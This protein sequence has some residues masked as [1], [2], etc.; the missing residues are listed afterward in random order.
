MGCMEHV[1][2]LF[3]GFP[4]I[5]KLFVVGWG[6]NVHRD[7]GGIEKQIPFVLWLLRASVF[8]TLGGSRPRSV[9]VTL[10]FLFFFQK[11]QLI[12]LVNVIFAE[13]F[14]KMN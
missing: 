3:Q 12:E 9:I 2:D 11:Q 1:N 7:A 8:S 10:G 5:F 4:G 13:T 6:L 14:A